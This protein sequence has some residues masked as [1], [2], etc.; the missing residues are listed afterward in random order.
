MMKKI[1]AAAALLA[2]VSFAAA[3]PADSGKASF[4]G[5]DS[6]KVGE[7]KRDSIRLPALPDSIKA[8]IANQVKA[9]DSTKANFAKDTTKRVENKA[10]V[11]S[12]R[13]TWE[14]KRDSQVSHIKD[15]AVRAKVEAR[16]T[17]VAEHKAA[18][19]AKIEAK[20][21]AKPAAE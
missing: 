13:M 12:L 15:P 4:K 11:D 2:A 6:A 17:K 18:M 21:A 5:K 7:F 20:K 10:K 14:A 8:K 3:T 9:H 19:K 1:L 16:I